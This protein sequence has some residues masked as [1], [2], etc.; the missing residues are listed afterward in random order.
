MSLARLAKEAAKLGSRG[1][2]AAAAFPERKVAVL[3]AAGA[4]GGG[5]RGAFL[6]RRRMGNGAR[7][8][9]LG[10][11]GGRGGQNPHDQ[12]A[13]PPILAAAEAMHAC[14]GGGGGG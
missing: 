14:G 2:A 12:G 5:G 7:W 10:S 8:A 9:R 3:G 6:G 4:W 11:L 13:G 1:Y